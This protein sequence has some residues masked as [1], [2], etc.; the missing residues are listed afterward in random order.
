MQS[1]DRNLPPPMAEARLEEEQ[2][3]GYEVLLRLYL[4]GRAPHRTQLLPLRETHTGA[5]TP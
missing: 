2:T 1:G 5:G 4:R 3:S